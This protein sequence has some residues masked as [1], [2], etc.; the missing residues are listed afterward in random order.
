MA[1]GL[2]RDVSVWFLDRRISDFWLSLPA[3]LYTAGRETTDPDSGRVGRRIPRASRNENVEDG[4]TAGVDCNEE[5]LCLYLSVVRF[6]R[7]AVRCVGRL[8]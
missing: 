3:G 6:E 1:A 4:E 2:R 8:C 7:K 5:C